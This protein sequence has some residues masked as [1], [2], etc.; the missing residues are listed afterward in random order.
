VPP[1]PPAEKPQ[2]TDSTG[3]QTIANQTVIRS[4]ARGVIELPDLGRVQVSAKGAGI[5]LSVRVI[6]DHPETT[7]V[8]LP[9][10][11]AMAAE[12]RG[13]ERAPVRIDIATRDGRVAGDDQ[14][15]HGRR[16][17]PEHRESSGLPDDSVEPAAARTPS[18]SSVRIVL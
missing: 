4:E 10:A 18:R 6:A 9:H 3:A 15:S 2:P 12:V 8:L 1:S 5:D 17:E 7:A 14:G 13:P 11:N 16:R